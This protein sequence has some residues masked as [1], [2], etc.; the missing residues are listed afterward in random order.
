MCVCVCVCVAGP[1]FTLCKYVCDSA[2]GG[3]ILL[4]ASSLPHVDPDMLQNSAMVSRTH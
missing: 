1:S 2:C 4:S 3:M